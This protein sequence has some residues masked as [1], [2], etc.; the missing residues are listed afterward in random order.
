MFSKFVQKA[1][2]LGKK[3]IGYVRGLNGDKAAA[4]AVG[5]ITG[6]NPAYG[7]IASPFLTKLGSYINHKVD[8]WLAEDR[9]SGGVKKPMSFE[10]RKALRERVNEQNKV[11][12]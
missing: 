6:Y 5:A 9:F 10:E 2:D 8:K 1:K 11:Y 7:V 4:W 12:T 3:A